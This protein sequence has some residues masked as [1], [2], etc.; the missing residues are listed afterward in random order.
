M[1]SV[2]LYAACLFRYV[3]GRGEQ[4]HCIVQLRD[5]TQLVTR[6]KIQIQGMLLLESIKTFVLKFVSFFKAVSNV[7]EA[8]KKKLINKAFNDTG[9]TYRVVRVKKGLCAS[10]LIYT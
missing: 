1:L 8:Q 3:H 9:E 6:L 2:N 4:I 5:Y 10:L 7:L